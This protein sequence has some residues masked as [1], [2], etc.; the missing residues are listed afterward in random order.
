[1]HG[2]FVSLTLI[3]A[4]CEENAI[5]LMEVQ[6]KFKGLVE[7]CQDGKWKTVCNQGWDDREARVVCRQLGF[8]EDT[9]GELLITNIARAQGVRGHCI[10]D[11]TPTSDRGQ[12]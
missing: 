11:C 1:M 3:V 5:R 8:A 9:R 10:S 4:G 2:L 12:S 6:N 7:V